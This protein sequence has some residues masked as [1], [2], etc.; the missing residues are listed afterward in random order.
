MMEA[1]TPC[2]QCQQVYLY[3]ELRPR[4][5]SWVYTASSPYEQ[6]LRRMLSE[7]GRPHSYCPACWEIIYQTIRKKC[8]GEYRLIVLLPGE[9]RLVEKHNDRARSYGGEA[10]LTLPQWAKTLD[11]YDWR[12]AYCGGPYQELEHWIPLDGGGGTT[13]INCVPSCRS[14]NRRKGTRHPHE[15]M[16]V[17]SSLSP[18]VHR[19]IQAEMEALHGNMP[20]IP[21]SSLHDGEA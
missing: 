4:F 7:A 2:Q 16:E 6:M 11:H 19:R 20:A 14:C 10:T 18:S 21:S 15:I 13:A 3:K 12:C 17:E 9:A 1:P 5:F 8:D